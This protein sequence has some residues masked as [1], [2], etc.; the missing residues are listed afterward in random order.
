[1][2]KQLSRVRILW[3][4]DGDVEDVTIGDSLAEI[5]DVDGNITARCDLTKL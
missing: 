5:L 4:A 2:A 1:M 3:D